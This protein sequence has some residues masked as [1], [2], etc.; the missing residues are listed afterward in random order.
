MEKKI[1]SIGARI[2][3]I[4]KS[5]NLTLKIFAFQLGISQSYLSEVE[6]DLKKPGY[7]LFYSLKTY[8]NISIDWLITGKKEEPY[9][10]DIQT[11]VDK[12]FDLLSTGT[13]EERDILRG[14]ISEEHR[15]H[16]DSKLLEAARKAMERKKRA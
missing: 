1:F 5:K 6:R 3:Q 4:R 8:F 13:P 12:V 10:S 16:Y 15:K 2:K 7:E 9:P 14:K 11:Y